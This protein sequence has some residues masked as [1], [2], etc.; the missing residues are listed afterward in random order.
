MKAD[1]HDLATRRFLRKAFVLSGQSL[2]IGYAVSFEL[3]AQKVADKLL[4]AIRRPLM[5]S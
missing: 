3:G 4:E 5:Q 2:Q 1:T